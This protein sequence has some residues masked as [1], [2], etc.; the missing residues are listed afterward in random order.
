MFIYKNYCLQSIYLFSN[1]EKKTLRYHVCPIHTISF[2]S[3]TIFNYRVICRIITVGFLK[4]NIQSLC[5]KI[6]Y[7]FGKVLKL[8]ASLWIYLVV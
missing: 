2:T 1:V 4:H 6:F 5:S 7:L 8:I 3:S